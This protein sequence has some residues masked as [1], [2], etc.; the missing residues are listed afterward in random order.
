MQER[1]RSAR[2]TAVGVLG[3]LLVNYPLVSLVDHAGRRV[4]G[5]P[6]LWAYLFA[7]WAALIALL[8]VI[9]RGTE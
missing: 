8:A 5:V 7:V 2:F 4:L 3:L 1:L 9:A 6:L